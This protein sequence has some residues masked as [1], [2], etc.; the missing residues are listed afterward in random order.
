MEYRHS[1]MSSS[2]CEHTDTQATRT[3]LAPCAS[4]KPAASAVP[5][6]KRCSE[7]TAAVTSTCWKEHVGVTTDGF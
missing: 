4:W 1:T 6:K 7:P 2:T 3:D 5:E